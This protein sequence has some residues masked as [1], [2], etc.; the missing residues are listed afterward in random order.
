MPKI[1]I[2]GIHS[3]I[4]KGPTKVRKLVDDQTL[5]SSCVSFFAECISEITFLGPFSGLNKIDSIFKNLENGNTYLLTSLIFRDLW[6]LSFLSTTV[7][8]E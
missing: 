8:L 5:H 6:E 4:F 3:P 2:I 1:S 7:D